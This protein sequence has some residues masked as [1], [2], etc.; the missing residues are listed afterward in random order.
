MNIHTSH[1]VLSHCER[2]SSN[3]LYSIIFCMFG[4]QSDGNTIQIV[5]RILQKSVVNKTGH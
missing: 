3:L 1:L 4:R 2:G 5:K